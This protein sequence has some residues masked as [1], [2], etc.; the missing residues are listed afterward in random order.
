MRRRVECGCGFAVEG[1]DD[2]LVEAARIHARER[3][4]VE[5]GRGLVLAAATDVGAP[6]DLEMTDVRRL[7]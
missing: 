3:H 1:D 7:R 4:G 6:P 2:D 5:L